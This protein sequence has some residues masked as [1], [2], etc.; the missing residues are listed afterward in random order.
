MNNFFTIEQINPKLQILE[1]RYLQIRKEFDDSFN[2]LI[3]TNWNGDNDYKQ[4][5]ESPY[6]G[7]KV[8]PLMVDSGN[9]HKNEIDIFSRELS[10]SYNQ[11]VSYDKESNILLFENG[12][13]LP[14]LISTLLECGIKKR[15]GISVVFPDKEIK[16][17]IDPDPETPEY[18]IIRGLWGLSINEEDVGES[19]ICL[20]DEI[21]HQ[22]IKFENNKFTFFWGRTKHMV[23]NT[24]Q[25]PRYV[26]L[27][28]QDISRDLLL[29]N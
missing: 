15:V 20:G 26:V 18:A 21:N 8:A 11:N 7:W 28:D 6:K 22:R 17:H 16:W 23:L 5:S 10:V 4:I 3:W 29:G 9:I 13:Y 2:Q 24:L 27:F 14:T 1:D 19:F 12:K 25:T